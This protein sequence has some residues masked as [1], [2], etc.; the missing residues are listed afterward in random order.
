[1]TYVIATIQGMYL[2]K[3]TLEYDP[4]H[5]MSDIYFVDELA[6]AHHYEMEKD[7]IDRLLQLNQV[8]SPALCYVIDPSIKLQYSDYAVR[9]PIFGGDTNDTNAGNKPSNS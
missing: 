3:Q 8:L 7:A 9:T 1:M 2:G 5:D 4:E 6:R